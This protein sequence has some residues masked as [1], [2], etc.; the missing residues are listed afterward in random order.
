MTDITHLLVALKI[1]LA[2]GLQIFDASAVAKMHHPPIN[3]DVQA[4]VTHIPD[5]TVATALKQVLLNQYPADFDITFLQADHNRLE[6]TLGEA[7]PENMAYPSDIY[8]PAYGGYASFEAFQEIIAHLRAPE[9][10]P[11]DR[12]QTHLS[13]RKYLLEE[14]YEVLEALNEEDTDHLREE[15]GDLLLQ[16]LLHTQIATE[17]N[18]FRMVDVMRAI[19]NKLIYR[20]PHVWG[21]TAVED[22]DQVVEN[23]DALKKKEHAK[24][25]VRRESILDGV[26]KSASSLLQAYEYTAK[27]AKVGFDW[28]DISGVQAKIQEEMAEIAEANDDERESEFGDLL[29]ALVNWARWLNIE[30]ESALRMTNQKFYRR[31][32]YIEEQASLKETPLENLDLQAMDALWDEAKAKGL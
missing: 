20:H 12:K 3:P 24:K 25:G 17:A 22:A 30:P 15:L 5:A 1:N 2:D 29:F 11:W 13:L 6:T 16:I 23:W 10:C 21:Q 7:L 18:H 9:G 28:D 19:N 8:L 31:F 26:P 14:S 4:V 32:H 27:A